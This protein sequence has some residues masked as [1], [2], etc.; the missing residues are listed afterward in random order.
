M[1]LTLVY[2]LAFTIWVEQMLIVCNFCN[3]EFEEIRNES[4]LNK[5]S[6]LNYIQQTWSLHQ[7][8]YF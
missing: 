8:F 1:D 4:E 7:K 6:I 5:I 3:F 2:I